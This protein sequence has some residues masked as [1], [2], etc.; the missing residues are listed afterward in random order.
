[1][2]FWLQIVLGIATPVIALMGVITAIQNW[3]TAR[4]KLKLDLFEKRFAVYE[5][6]RN[7][8]GSIVTSGK[9]KD[10]EMFKFLSG[11]REAKWI[12]SAEVAKYLDS[13]LYVLL[14]RTEF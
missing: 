11:T 14:A 10:D 6:A 8:I 4:D 12:L 1:M 13:S 9:T 5:V 2:P 7:F 3:L